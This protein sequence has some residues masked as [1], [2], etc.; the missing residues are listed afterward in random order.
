MTTKA[1]PTKPQGKYYA[2][3]LTGRDLIPGVTTDDEA[4]DFLNHNPKLVPDHVY[5]IV[6]MTVRSVAT[7]AHNSKEQF[8]KHGV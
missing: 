1:Q 7:R 5:E 3:H 6:H 4:V 8:K 2:Q